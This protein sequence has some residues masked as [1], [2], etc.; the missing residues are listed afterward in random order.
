MSAKDAAIRD[1]GGGANQ[2]GLRDQNARLVL[3]FLRRHG[4]M[5][6][7]EIARRSG[8]SPQTVSNIIRALEGQK[9][10]RRRKAVKGKVG[11]PSVPMALNPMGALSL[12]L[13]IGRRAAE[14]TLLDFMGDQIDARA[15]SYAYPDMDQVFGFLETAL[16]DILRAGPHERSLLTGIGV[17][18][19]NRIWDWLEKVDAPEPAMRRWQD[20]DVAEAVGQAT[21]L[22]VFIENDATSACVSELL[23]GRGNEV[24]D[25]AYIFVGAFVGGGLVL[26]GKVISGRARNGA[27]LGPMPVP[28]GQGGTTQLLSVTSLYALEAEMKRVGRDPKLLRESPG[29]WSAFEDALVPWLKK[30]GHY[31]AIACASIASVVEVEAI[32]IDGAMPPDVRQRLTEQT[33]RSYQELDLTG[34]EEF[35]IA[36]GS[37][38]KRARSVGAA[39]LPIH[40]RYFLA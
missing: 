29:D 7:A 15:T 10:I 30:T 13:N 19:P 2:S 23:L 3:S 12:G 1:P 38:G 21:G 17:S 35:L 37:V 5:P 4:E 22:E 40:S 18:V 32:V 6:S 16:E 31:L 26:D 25:F 27:A 33:Q 8:L 14:L 36:P 11:K 34:L 24:S 20:L 9:L 39:L 28:D